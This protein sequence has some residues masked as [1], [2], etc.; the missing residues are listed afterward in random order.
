MF[1]EI[2]LPIFLSQFGIG[3]EVLFIFDLYSI[4]NFMITDNNEEIF[5]KA[6]CGTDKGIVSGML[7]RVK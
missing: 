6:K 1:F 2:S 3:F 5:K 7:F 4:W